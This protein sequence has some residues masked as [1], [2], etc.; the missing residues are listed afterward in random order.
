MSTE[1]LAQHVMAGRSM[2][3]ADKEPYEDRYQASWFSLA[4]PSEQGRAVF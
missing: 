4:A 1:E 2:N 3:T